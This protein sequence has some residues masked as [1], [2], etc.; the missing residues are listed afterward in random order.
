MDATLDPA[1]SAKAHFKDLFDDVEDLIGRVADI[2][3]PEIQ[4][5]RA[6]VRVA[7]KL[8]RSA[9]Q[10][11]ATHVRR[12]AHQ[13]ASSTEGYLRDYPWRALGLGVLLGFGLGRLTWRKD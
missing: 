4:K 11:G 5:I 6:K 3:S 12:Q 10:D 2:E 7:S 8:A 13:A 9:L 1:E